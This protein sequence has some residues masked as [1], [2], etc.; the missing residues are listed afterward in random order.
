MTMLLTNHD[1]GVDLAEVIL[2]DSSVPMD[3]TVLD[4]MQKYRDRVF[5]SD[6]CLTHVFLYGME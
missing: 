5:M 4:A 1:V 6:A 2:L 3:P